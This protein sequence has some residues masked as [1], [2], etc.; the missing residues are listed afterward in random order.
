MQVKRDGNNINIQFSKEILLSHLSWPFIFRYVEKSAQFLEFYCYYMSYMFSIFIKIIFECYNLL[1][2]LVP[3]I[4]QHTEKKIYKSYLTILNVL[5]K[6]VWL[7]SFYI[8]YGNN[9]RFQTL[10]WCLNIEKFGK[11]IPWVLNTSMPIFRLVAFVE[12]QN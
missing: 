9:N 4:I 3:K 7:L 8:A 10:R 2:D 5:K 12:L 6:F 1:I 11:L